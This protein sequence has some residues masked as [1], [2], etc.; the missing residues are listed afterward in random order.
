ML[1]FDRLLKNACS[2]KLIIDF[3]HHYTV[4]RTQKTPDLIF[5]DDVQFI[6]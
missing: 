1:I 6:S 4:S 3:S 5:F 2:V